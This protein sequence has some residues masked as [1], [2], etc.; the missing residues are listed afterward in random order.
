MGRVCLLNSTGTEVITPASQTDIQAI[1]TQLIT[2]LA[3]PS[4][5][6]TADA[7]AS[8][9]AAVAPTT[10][11]TATVEI[12]ATGVAQALLPGVA[13]CGGFHV[14]AQKTAAN[15]DD[16]TIGDVTNQDLPV[17]PTDYKGFTIKLNA[18]ADPSDWYCKGT[19]GDKVHLFIFDKVAV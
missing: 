19:A 16:V 4:G 7:Q 15:A 2:A 14:F 6:A 8:L 3:L 13:S 12:V 11:T 18:L 5:A 9:L 17:E 10:F 1:V